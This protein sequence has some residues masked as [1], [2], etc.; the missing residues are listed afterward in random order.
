AQE[1]VGYLIEADSPYLRRGITPFWAK[2]ILVVRDEHVLTAAEAGPVR[3]GD[4]VYL[5][6]PPEKAAALD[7]FFVDMPP[8]SSPDPRLLGDFFVSADAT[9]GA[10]A[11]IYGLALDPALPATSAAA[12]HSSTMRTIASSPSVSAA[13]PGC[14]ISAD[15][16][17][18]KKPARTAG[19]SPKPG[20]LPTL[21]GTNFL[22]HLDPIMMSGAAAMTSSGAAIRS[23]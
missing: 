22:P 18:R 21:A 11:A 4:Y 1:L 8:P 15:L 6:A 17:S 9:L 20:R 7:R 3:P 14:R 13:G 23:L 12:R 2:P 16:I 10:L 19:I 5:L